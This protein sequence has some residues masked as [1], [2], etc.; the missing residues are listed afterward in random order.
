MRGRMREEEHPLAS[1]STAPVI[2]DI[3]PL[4]KF[5][6]ESPQGPERDGHVDICKGGRLCG[7]EGLTQEMETSGVE[8]Q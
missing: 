6:G 4:G 5:P 2:Q 7:S 3:R 1:R 8:A